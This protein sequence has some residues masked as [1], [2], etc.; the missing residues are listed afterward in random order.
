MNILGRGKPLTGSSFL[1]YIGPK[2]TDL[3]YA[4][5]TLDVEDQI[6]DQSEVFIPM[7]CP[8]S[9][10]GRGDFFIHDFAAVRGTGAVRGRGGIGPGR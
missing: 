7:N 8:C 6:T 5:R 2:E 4:K 10:P 9:R 3:S 1:T